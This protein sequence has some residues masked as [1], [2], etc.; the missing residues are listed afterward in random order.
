MGTDKV[1][2]ANMALRRIGA[3]RISSFGDP[4]PEAQAVSDIY[5]LILDEVL[6]SGL[7]TF[8]QAQSALAQLSLTSAF[9]A[10][11]L[12]YIY[13]EPA[14]LLKINFIN[15]S[16]A[17]WKRE[18]MSGQNVIRANIPGLQIIYTFRNTD[19]TTY[20]PL[21]IAALA[22]RLSYELCFALSESRSFAKDVFDEYHKVKLPQALSAD[23]QQGSPVQ[24]IQN[25]WENAR[26]MSGTG[27]FAQPG[28][29][30]WHPA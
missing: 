3:K 14:N 2:I 25:E 18:A 1:A 21:F 23:S 9:T 5:D 28:Q 22:S 26:N 15:D 20:F 10:D 24:A 13:A 30:T 16:G 12:A 11:G 7:W 17:T 4:S 27:I 19:P 29:Q 8:A 6:C